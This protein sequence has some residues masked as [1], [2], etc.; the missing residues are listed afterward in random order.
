[1]S[2]PQVGIISQARMTS[3]RLP[4]KVLLPIN[5]R[6]V[7]QYHLDRLK[8]SGYPI[9]LAITNNATD[10]PLA[11]FGREHQV[12]VYRG[13]EQHVLRRYYEAARAFNLDVIVRVTSDC[14]L[15]DGGLLRQGIQ[16][17]VESKDSGLYLSNCLLRT[18]PRGLDFE[19]F[20]FALLQ[21]A[22]H[23]ATTAGELEHVTPYINQNK[24]GHVRFRHLTQAE[25]KS[26]YRVTLDTPEDFDLIRIL[27]AD[28][29]AHQLTAREIGQLLDAHPE[30]VRINAMV[31]QKKA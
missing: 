9:F 25:D 21:E 17:Y 29:Q 6:P 12:P 5:Q 11:A 23:Q 14:P 24:S 2:K 18:F 1:M 4:G 26:Q 19:I 30:L 22:F 3:T 27:I 15:I 8:Q 7:L 13:D 31:E 10:D 16:E 20:S 28:Y